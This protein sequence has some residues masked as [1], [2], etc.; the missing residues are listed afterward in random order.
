VRTAGGEPGGSRVADLP[1][2]PGPVPG[3]AWAT[4]CFGGWPG[5][6]A[7]FVAVGAVADAPVEWA[8]GVV[9]GAAVVGAPAGAPEWF[10][11]GA[12]GAVAVGS[13]GLPPGR[14][15]APVGGTGGPPWVP[16]TGSVLAWGSLA[17]GVASGL[18]S[19]LAGGL[20]GGAAGA[21]PVGAAL[22]GVAG[23]VPGLAV[24]RIVALGGIGALPC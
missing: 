8:G 20:A 15:P 2:S 16:G 23:G 9:P 5:T 24:G 18:A 12:P 6:A 13:P 1:W 14:G 21:V 17:G 3:G 10:G 22:A 7:G 19:G 4:G 11:S